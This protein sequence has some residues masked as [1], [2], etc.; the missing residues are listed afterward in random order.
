MLEFSSNRAKSYSLCSALLQRWTKACKVKLGVKYL[1]GLRPAEFCSEFIVIITTIIITTEQG[2]VR[3]KAGSSFAKSSFH[4]V[5]AEYSGIYTSQA[6]DSKKSSYQ[7]LSD[8][9]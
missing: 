9:L 4:A 1:T 8:L 2:A 3:L 5:Y 6:N 7:W